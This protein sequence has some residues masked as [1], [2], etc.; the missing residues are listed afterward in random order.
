MTE[1][2]LHHVGGWLLAVGGY[3]NQGGGGGGGNYGSGNQGGGNYG[4][5][6]NRR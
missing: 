3:G 6:Y 1:G 4:G 5:G 2:M